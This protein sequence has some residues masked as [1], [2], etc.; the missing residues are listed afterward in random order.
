MI[1]KVLSKLKVKLFQFTAS[2]K[3]AAASDAEIFNF[4][5]QS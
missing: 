3:E 2:L 5:E 1:G 4:P